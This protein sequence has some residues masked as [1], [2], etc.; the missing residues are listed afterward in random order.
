[1]KSLKNLIAVVATS[2]IISGCVTTNTVYEEEV[3]DKVHPTLPRGIKAYYP[4][5]YLDVFEDG[6]LYTYMSFKDSQNLRLMLNDTHRYIKETN[7][8]LC[9]YRKNL[10][11]E[12]C[13]KESNVKK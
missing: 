3:L 10:N 7:D 9:F 8:L 5:L 2:I 12:F 1:M 13:I 4:T 11:E 6:E